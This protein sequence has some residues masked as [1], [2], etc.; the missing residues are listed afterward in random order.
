MNPNIEYYITPKSSEY[1]HDIWKYDPDAD[2]W[3]FFIDKM[4]NFWPETDLGTW[5]QW[6][7]STKDKRPAIKRPV[8]AK[9]VSYEEIFERLL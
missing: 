7:P 5:R 1:T 9:K 4:H 3:Y 6:S 8:G 2:T